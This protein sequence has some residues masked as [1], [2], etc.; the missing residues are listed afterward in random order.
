MLCYC[1]VISR[2]NVSN[3]FPAHITSDNIHAVRK[4]DD[5]DDHRSLGALTT[6]RIMMDVGIVAI[7]EAMDMSVQHLIPSNTQP[8]PQKDNPLQGHSCCKHWNQFSVNSRSFIAHSRSNTHKTMSCDCR[9]FVKDAACT[10]SRP[11][12]LFT[13]R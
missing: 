6:L 1:L 5:E 10:S 8:S 4:V 13:G 12:S 11:T 7:K 3:G 2:T 9:G